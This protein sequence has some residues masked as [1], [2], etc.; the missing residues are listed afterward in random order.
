[1]SINSERQESTDQT[2]AG[3]F[4]SAHSRHAS[5]GSQ[6]ATNLA[7]GVKKAVYHV[8]TSEDQDVKRVR[9]QYYHYCM[10]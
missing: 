5:I 6:T 4:S 2:L 9:D 8:S 3:K 7:R 10:L 1:M